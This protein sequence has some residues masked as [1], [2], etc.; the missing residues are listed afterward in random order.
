MINVKFTDD[1]N[2]LVTE[3]L[4]QWDTYQTLK[5][6][7][8]NF[9][10]ITPRVHFANKKSKEALVVKAI[11]KSDG[12]AEV[13]IPNSLL[14]EKYDILAYIYT[15]TGLTYKTIKSI[16]IPVISR[17]K[18]S[19]YFQPTNEEIIEIGEIELQA[20]LILSKLYASEYKSNEKYSRPNIV[21]YNHSSYMCLSDEEISGVLPTDTSKWQLI[22]V[23]A[24]VTSLTKDS[25]GNI[26]FN[27]SNG[28]SFT[29]E[30]AVKDAKLVDGDDVPALKLTFDE[31]DKI[32]KTKVLDLTDEQVANCK[33]V[34]LTGT[35]NIDASSG[36][37]VPTKPGLYCITVIDNTADIY[38]SILMSI[39]NII[40]KVYRSNI[41]KSTDNY[42]CLVEYKLVN[43]E[44]GLWGFK[45]NNINT[46]T[47]AIDNVKCILE[48]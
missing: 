28:S 8:I 10:S 31:V 38:Y 33:K 37:Y 35:V 43:S 4:Y 30:M 39:E 24:V 46:D 15:N 44:I 23:G 2:D 22:A 17:L 32:Q 36:G 29:V 40:G 21:Y 47:W 34:K 48:Y 20:K 3:N 11:L 16:T 6:S 25:N 12:T 9:D 1:I 18:P 42:T 26:I 7:G 19:E 45:I 13:S 27:F 14:T 41:I 5:I